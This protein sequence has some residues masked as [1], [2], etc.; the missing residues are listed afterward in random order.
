MRGQGTQSCRRSTRRI[1]RCRSCTRACPVVFHRRPA[2]D[3]A[4]LVDDRG[5]DRCRRRKARGV[6]LGR[7]RVRRRASEGGWPSGDAPAVAKPPAG[8]SCGAGRAIGHDAPVPWPLPVSQA[9]SVVTEPISMSAGIWQSSSGCM[10]ASPTPLPVISV[11][12]IPGVCSS[13]RIWVLRQARQSTRSAVSRY[14]RPATRAE[15]GFSLRTSTAALRLSPSVGCA[16][17]A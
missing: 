6:S 5:H 13:T 8:F 12:R 16:S 4:D 3:V 10:G 11:A 15:R 1:R 17:V 14:G 2:S 9:P 7:P